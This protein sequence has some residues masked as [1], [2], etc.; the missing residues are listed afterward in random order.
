MKIR[1]ISTPPIVAAMGLALLSARPTCGA[2][3]TAEALRLRFLDCDRRASSM[4]LDFADA[5]RCSHIYEQL[6]RGEFQGDFGKLMAWWRA[7][8]RDPLAATAAPRR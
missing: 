5:A 1:E 7:Q 4:L 2:E 3:L 8:P 6:L